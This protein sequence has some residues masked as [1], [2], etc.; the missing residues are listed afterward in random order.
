MAL[1]E[2]GYI[3]ILP[4]IIGSTGFGEK[5]CED[6]FGDWGGRPYHD[7]VKCWEYV[8]DKFKFADMERAVCLG[9]SY[10]G[11]SLGPFFIQR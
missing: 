10:G 8:E 3:V 7:L 2:Q 9:A 6:V 4:N 1:A 11:K 5:F